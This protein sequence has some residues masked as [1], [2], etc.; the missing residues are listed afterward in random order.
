MASL[1]QPEPGVAAVGSRRRLSRRRARSGGCPVQVA[2]GAVGLEEGEEFAVL[3]VAL[4][5]QVCFAGELPCVLE[6]GGSDPYVVLEDAD[7]DSAARICAQSRLIN[8]GQSCIAAKRFIVHKSVV[9]KFTEVFVPELQKKHIG[10]MARK[11]LRDELQ[12]QVDRSVKQGAKLV[13]GGKVPSGNGFHYPATV[14][15]GVRPGSY[16]LRVVDVNGVST[17]PFVIE[18]P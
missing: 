1:R 12:R 14:L 7:V 3:V 11:D 13:C 10:P 16:V 5:P 17:A 18:R 4:L 8:A 9:A 6:L 15:T 2:R